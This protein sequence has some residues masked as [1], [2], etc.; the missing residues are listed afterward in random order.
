MNLREADLERH[1]TNGQ[2]SKTD[3][4]PLKLQAPKKETPKDKG[5]SKD[6]SKG[7]GSY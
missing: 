4:A 1:L 3:H 7:G 5:E 6:E 2:D